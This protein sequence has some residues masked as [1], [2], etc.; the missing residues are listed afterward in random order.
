MPVS[1]LPDDT[2]SKYIGIPTK[3]I[4]NTKNYQDHAPEVITNFPS[5]ST[6]LGFDPLG[7]KRRKQDAEIAKNNYIIRG[8]YHQLEYLLGSY[9]AV[10]K[11][12]D[13]RGLYLP[14]ETFFQ[15]EIL[16]GGSSA[17]AAI[18]IAETVAT[19]IVRGIAS[20]IPAL[21]RILPAPNH[22]LLD[23]GQQVSLIR[24]LNDVTAQIIAN[25]PS[26]TTG[27]PVSATTTT[28][29]TS[30]QRPARPSRITKEDYS[31]YKKPDTS[32]SSSSSRNV[33]SYC[34][35]LMR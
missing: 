11:Q 34:A 18:D 8:K 13:S 23:I 19:G 17:E 32:S 22:G 29:D 26:T 16:Q 25:P 4:L 2:P 12:F 3:E 7:I 27:I 21:E 6:S 33:S 28:V 5:V 31:D 24:D 10:K 35:S 1:P 20:G 9:A 14:P 15:A 30:K